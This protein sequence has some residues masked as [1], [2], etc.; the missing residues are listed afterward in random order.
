M[1]FAFVMCVPPHKPHVVKPEYRSLH[2]ARQGIVLLFL[3]VGVWYLN[4]RLGSFNDKHPVFSWLL[5]AAE[6]FGF[7]TAIL[8]I[9]MTWRLSVR[10]A[11]PPAGGLK[12]DVFIPTYNED[13]EMV[14]RTALAARAMDYPHETWILDD[15]NREAMRK[16][17][18]SLGVRYLSR[19]NN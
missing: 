13:I 11:P 10:T 7:T 19:T 5:Y 14:R 16:M 18:Q 1:G 9:F 8:N 3:A 17:A 2:R 15:G 12:V 4:W 6:V